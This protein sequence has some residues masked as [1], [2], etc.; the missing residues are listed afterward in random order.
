MQIKNI[1]GPSTV[2]RGTPDLT[3]IHLDATPSTVTHCFLLVSQEVIQWLCLIM[4]LI[5]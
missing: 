3:G 1:N 5:R 4:N 2:P